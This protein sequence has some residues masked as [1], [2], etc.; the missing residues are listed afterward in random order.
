MTVEELIRAREAEWNAAIRRRDVSAMDQY[1]AESFC[2][3]IAIE[4]EPLQVVPRKQW[5][6]TLKV[7]LLDFQ[8]IDDTRIS[9]YGDTDLAILAYRQIG[10]TPGN[11]DISGNFLLTD[12]WVN[13][14]NGWRAAERH[15]SRQEKPPASE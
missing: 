8:A 5:L 10:G 4:G 14:S 1:L 2:V 11:R 6:E 13:T 3:V 15:S 12:V 9:V 7:Y